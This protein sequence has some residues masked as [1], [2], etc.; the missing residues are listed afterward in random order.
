M[1]WWLDDLAWGVVADHEGD[2]FVH[3]SMIEGT[4]YRSLPEGERVGIEVGTARH[5][6]FR[7]AERVWREG[8]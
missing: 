8:T 1:R 2:V 4:G 6:M 3:F 5:G 7:R